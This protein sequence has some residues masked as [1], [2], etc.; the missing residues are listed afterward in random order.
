M[1]FINA[2]DT[3][4]GQKLPYLVP[5]RHVDHPVL[6]RNLSRFPSQSK[7]ARKKNSPVDN[8]QKA[9]AVGDDNEGVTPDAEADL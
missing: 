3:R 8:P 9:P 5:E 2:Y 6:G 7:K 4:T 1:T